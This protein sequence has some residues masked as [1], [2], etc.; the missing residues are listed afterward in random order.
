MA[1]TMQEI[2]TQILDEEETDFQ[3]WYAEKAIKY[4]LN[5]DPDD[6]RHHYDYRAA[7]KAKVEPDKLGHWPSKFKDE[8]HPNRFINGIDTITG[9]PQKKRSMRDIMNQILS[10]E[11]ELTPEQES[12]ATFFKKPFSMTTPQEFISFAKPDLEKFEQEVKQ[13]RAMQKAEKKLGVAGYPMAFLIGHGRGWIPGLKKLNE[14]LPDSM[15]KALGPEGKF[16]W[17]SAVGEATGM[18]DKYYTAL[19]LTAPLGPKIAVESII[20]GIPAADLIGLSAPRALVWGGIKLMDNISKL[21]AGM[22]KPGIYNLFVDPLI[23]SLAGGSLGLATGMPTTTSA[24]LTGTAGIGIKEIVPII[25]DVWEG[26]KMD[27]GTV[28]LDL[29]ISLLWTGVIEALG[30][31]QMQQAWQTAQTQ[32]L[33]EKMAIKITENP[34]YFKNYTLH[35]RGGKPSAPYKPWEI[36]DLSDIKNARIIA[37]FFLNGFSQFAKEPIKEAVQPIVE[38]LTA[39]PTP[40]QEAVIS[41]ITKEVAAGIPPSQVI[42][43]KVDEISKEAIPSFEKTEEPAILEERKKRKAAFRLQF[44]KDMRDEVAKGEEGKRVFVETPEEIGPGHLKITGQRSSFPEW[45]RNKGLLK[46][47]TLNL[48]DKAIAGKKRLVQTQPEQIEKLIQYRMDQFRDESTAWGKKYEDWIK[49]EK[50]SEGY[51]PEEIET[52][53][54][55][56]QNEAQSEIDSGNLKIVDPDKEE[57]NTYLEQYEKDHPDEEF[58]EY[59]NKV[60]AE[61][62]AKKAAGVI[63]LPP[64]PSKPWEEAA[65]RIK[66]EKETAVPKPET[67]EHKSLREKG[68]FFEGKLREYGYTDDQIKV[69]KNNKSFAVGG[70]TDEEALRI[71]NTLKK[72]HDFE[73][74]KYEGTQKQKDAAAIAA[75]R[76]KRLMAHVYDHYGKNPKTPL[77]LPDELKDS[78]GKESGLFP[79]LRPTD[80][81]F[82]RNPIAYMGYKAMEGS[83]LDME[84][85]TARENKEAE[86]LAKKLKL[87][88][89]ERAQM[90]DYSDKIYNRSI[91]Q[92]GPPDRSQLPVLN[93]RQQQFYEYAKKKYAQR[94]ADGSDFITGK[95]E[96]YSPW[97]MPFELENE[98]L[99]DLD[100]SKTV[101]KDIWASFRKER[102]G[103]MQAKE[104][105]FVKRLEA[106][107]RRWARVKYLRDTVKDIRENI[108]PQLPADIGKRLETHVFR[109]LSYPDTRDQAV[110]QFIADQ[111]NKVGAKFGKEVTIGDVQKGLQVA[112]DLNYMSSMG[113]RPYTALNRI[114]GMIN[115]TADVGPEHIS[116]GLIRYITTKDDDILDRYKIKTDYTPEIYAEFGT[117]D[118]RTDM[119]KARDGM[120]IFFRTTDRIIRELTAYSAEIKF[121]E[122]WQ[123]AIKK[124]DKII[125]TMIRGQMATGNTD[126]AKQIFVREIVG[127]TQFFYG[128]KYSPLITRS[129]EGKIWMQY[130]QWPENQ[131]ELYAKWARNK[132]WQAGLTYGMILLGLAWLKKKTGAQ[133]LTRKLGFAPFMGP[134]ALERRMIPSTIEPIA[135]LAWMV[136]QPTYYLTNELD[137]DKAK[138]AFERNLKK[139]GRDTLNYMPGAGLMRDIYGIKDI[140]FPIPF[141]KEDVQYMQ[142]TAPVTSTPFSLR[143]PRKFQR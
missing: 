73:K 118:D 58:F 136:I 101:P 1:R 102:T 112:I 110:G 90:A 107:N 84:H 23:N 124:E 127:N 138:Q 93:E 24:I 75:A 115:T 142:P 39:L 56:A 36:T 92:K 63:P 111:A 22:E 117:M 100:R 91:N 122:N 97:M 34:D 113:L 16:G 67:S 19:G 139:F 12:L 74:S 33:A 128:K 5:P 53:N 126:K 66:T 104:M 49:Y 21:V 41:G 108:I 134:W 95:I 133:W 29:G 9:E 114:F 125:Q 51:S 30:H 35:T 44:L 79:W 31:E 96:E 10:E 37:N 99:M 25:R 98:F 60:T 40:T 72:A 87:T 45:F 3:K 59:I 77:D 69:L 105:D 43:E 129:L 38:K 70:M 7:Y 6:P 14:S 81:L 18:I 86:D 123:N 106:Y 27:F 32:Y 17:A 89:N 2:A 131:F 76:E 82:R 132:D 109:Q 140:G 46:E 48:L 47:D 85:F 80:K 62:K 94:F 141:N 78:I 55:I 137:E 11:P 68:K 28:G 4:D 57:F 52:A 119:A 42:P 54:R 64:E 103:A 71:T 143:Q 130:G 50:E 61:F 88:K 120:M 26:K 83:M 121:E 116:K 13:E 65:K 135:D 8:G 15:Q 20:K